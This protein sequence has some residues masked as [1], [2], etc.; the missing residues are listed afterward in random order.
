MDSVDEFV[1]LRR[2]VERLRAENARLSR[3]LD[4]RGQDTTPAPEQLFAPVAAPGLVTMVSPVAD[5]VLDSLV[6]AVASAAQPI[7]CV[8]AN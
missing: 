3:L 8:R 4:L 7:R 2:E 1:D 5:K 6:T